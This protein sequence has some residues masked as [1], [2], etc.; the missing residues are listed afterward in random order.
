M[1][2]W[3][4]NTLVFGCGDFNDHE[5]ALR[6]RRAQSGYKARSTVRYEFGEQALRQAQVRSKLED[7]R[8]QREAEAACREVWDD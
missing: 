2:G 6:A 4:R 8:I 7:M 5:R 3:H 1:S